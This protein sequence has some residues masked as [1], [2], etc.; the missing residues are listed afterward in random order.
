MTQNLEMTI[1]RTNR[2]KCPWFDAIQY[3]AKAQ[4]WFTNHREIIIH[5]LIFGSE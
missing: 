5:M 3:L 1:I 2:I 4:D